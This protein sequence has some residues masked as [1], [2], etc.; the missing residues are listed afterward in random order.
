MTREQVLDM[1]SDSDRQEDME[2]SEESEDELEMVDDPQEPIMEGSDDE[3]SDLGEVEDEE[4]EEEDQTN[5]LLTPLNHPSLP[6]PAVGPA[7]T[8]AQVS[9]RPPPSLPA[10][11]VGALAPT[12]TPTPTSLQVSGRPPS[13]PANAVGLPV[14]TPTP[15][16]TTSARVTYRPPSLPVPTPTPAPTTSARVTG[17]TPLPAS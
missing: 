7:P 17:R 11:T 15:A 4:E 16:P 8:S 6:T 13:L 2:L 9:L 5:A 10:N 3:F 12:A 14:P 1:L